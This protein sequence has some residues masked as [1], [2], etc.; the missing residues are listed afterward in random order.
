MLGEPCKWEDLGEGLSIDLSL[1]GNRRKG[2]WQLLRYV[3]EGD[4]MGEFL[5]QK[6]SLVVLLV[7]FY[8]VP[9]LLGGGIVSLCKS[10]SHIKIILHRFCSQES[11]IL[12]NLSIAN[13]IRVI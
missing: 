2:N 1:L 11:L 7:D 12:Y 6:E 3:C 9:I 4:G 5:M 13:R 10:N 8:D